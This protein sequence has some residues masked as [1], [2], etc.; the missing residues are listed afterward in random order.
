[1]SRQ[2][3]ITQT[4]AIT[5]GAYHAGDAVGG[6]LTFA[7]AASVYKGDG[8]ISKLTLVD[9]AKQAAVLTLW[10]FDRTFTASAD[11]L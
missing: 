2:R 11:L 1:M 7:N 8:I 4:P 5:A 3:E 6:L 10:L 9:N